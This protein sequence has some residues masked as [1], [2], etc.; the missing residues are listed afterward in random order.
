MV[1]LIYKGMEAGLDII[2]IFTASLV[3]P[4]MIKSIKGPLLQAD[5]MQTE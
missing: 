1:I 2:K 4:K 3:G 5:L